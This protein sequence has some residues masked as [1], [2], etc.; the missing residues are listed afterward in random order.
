ML[1]PTR[2]GSGVDLVRGG[3]AVICREL[4]R[5]MGQQGHAARPAG[6]EGISP[7]E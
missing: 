1:A 3:V 6:A 5:A 4:G 2:S 7:V